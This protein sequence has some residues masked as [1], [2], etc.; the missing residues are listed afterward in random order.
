MPIE[1]R[2]QSIKYYKCHRYPQM[3]SIFWCHLPSAKCANLKDLGSVVKEGFH[4]VLS[5]QW[6]INPPGTDL[7]FLRVL[8]SLP[9][10]SPGVPYR[11]QSQNSNSLDLYDAFRFFF[12]AQD[13]KYHPARTP[14]SWRL[15]VCLL[16][17]LH[18]KFQQIFHLSL[19]GGFN[20]V[21]KYDCSQIGI[22]PQNRGEK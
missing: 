8:V 10:C 7:V 18:S 9:H 20:P 17:F 6:S 14:A 5:V 16:P 15:D 22:L 3:I 11:H 1:T 19:V 12:N 2:R 4:D 13:A 21:E